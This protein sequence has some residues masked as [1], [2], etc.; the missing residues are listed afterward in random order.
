MRYR[1]LLIENLFKNDKWYKNKTIKKFDTNTRAIA[2]A[3]VFEF[4]KLLK[5]NYLI[6]FLEATAFGWTLIKAYDFIEVQ[7]WD[8]IQKMSL[9]SI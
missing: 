9:K 6:E 4:Q 8:T 5:E 7:R 3:K 1:T 2:A